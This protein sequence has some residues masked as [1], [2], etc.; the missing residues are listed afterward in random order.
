MSLLKFI[1]ILFNIRIWLS[2]KWDSLFPIKYSLGIIKNQKED[3]SITNNNKL[4][5][6]I[7]V[8]YE[9]RSKIYKIIYNNTTLNTIKKISIKEIPFN[10]GLH[11][12][13]VSIKI[14]YNKN[15]RR[16]VVSHLIPLLKEYKQTTN[17]IDFLIFNLNQIPSEENILFYKIYIQT[18]NKK[19]CF[20]YNQLKNIQISQFYK[21]LT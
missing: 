13:I 2:E 15:E 20:K 7:L 19:Y 18:F 1:T 6:K 12:P 14:K 11:K 16:H 8:K 21:L 17:F 4:Y 9:I 10:S 5:D 3:I